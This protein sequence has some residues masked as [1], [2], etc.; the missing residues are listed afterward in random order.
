MWTTSRMAGSGKT[1]RRKHSATAHRLR[2]AIGGDTGHEGK[3]SAHRCQRLSFFSMKQ[4]SC[5]RRYQPASTLQGSTSSRTTS[6][7]ATSPQMARPRPPS[8]FPAKAT[9]RPDGRCL[10]RTS[11]VTP[12]LFRVRVPVSGLGSGHHQGTRDIGAR[13]RT[14]VLLALA[15]ARAHPRRRRDKFPIADGPAAHP[16]WIPPHADALGEP[17]KEPVGEP[18]G[19]ADHAAALSSRLNAGD[20]H[21]AIDVGEGDAL[22]A[23]SWRAWRMRSGDHRWTLSR[24]G[25]RMWRRRRRRCSCYRRTPRVRP[26]L[27]LYHR[28]PCFR[29]L[30]LRHLPNRLGVLKTRC[31]KGMCQGGCGVQTL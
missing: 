23:G 8:P 13:P 7:R 16:R 11:R 27:C 22:A 17:V 28:L 15:Q 24:T 6:S 12:P 14:C 25:S 30:C 2:D 10:C 4:R 5:L 19:V 18:V 26:R 29:R 1:G 20:V 31:R 3:R 21:G 9:T